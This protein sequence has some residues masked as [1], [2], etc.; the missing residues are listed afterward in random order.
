M[1]LGTSGAVE[2]SNITSLIRLLG[3][4]ATAG[5]V[6]LALKRV[7][8]GK[9][10]SG[11]ALNLVAGGT[12]PR[13]R[14]KIAIIDD[15]IGSA[16]PSGQREALRLRGFTIKYLKDV[17]SLDEIS[18]DDILLCDVQGVGKSFSLDATGHGGLIVEE[19][20][21]VRPMVYIILYSGAANYSAAF[22][23]Y[24]SLADQCANLSSVMEEENLVKSLDR[25]ITEICTP[26]FQLKK[27]KKYVLEG[28]NISLATKDMHRLEKVFAHMSP[29]ES[30]NL[31]KAFL[32]AESD[33]AGSEPR[34]LGT[35]LLE[36]LERLGSLSG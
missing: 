9:P 17:P 21:R 31:E 28:R 12:I 8:A 20:R 4:I 6:V 10:K 30:A 16:V 27:L 11:A 33:S 29:R 32:Q 3:A 22:N 13:E 25:A 19:L 26:S 24:F 36:A 34:N 18:S 14:F 1:G 35:T 23:T 2:L 7:L 15:K 5:L